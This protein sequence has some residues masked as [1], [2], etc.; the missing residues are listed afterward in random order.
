M[1]RSF[2]PHVNTQMDSNEEHADSI[3]PDLQRILCW[4]A[5]F[6]VI[7]TIIIQ[8]MIREGWRRDE[9][10]H[11][12]KNTLF[13]RSLMALYFGFALESISEL[14][15]IYGI[16]CRCILLESIHAVTWLTARCITYFFMVQRAKMSQGLA[17]VLAPKWFKYHLP[18]SIVVLWLVFA[19]WIITNRIENPS[20]YNH[21]ECVDIDDIAY[22][23][24]VY[25]VHTTENVVKVG[26]GAAIETIIFGVL[27]YL[28]VKPFL[29]IYR[30]NDVD[31]HVH[32]L[33]RHGTSHTDDL[34]TA[35]KWNVSMSAISFVSS[36]VYCVGFALFGGYF[37]YLGPVNRVL[38]IW[39]AMFM[40]GRNRNWLYINVVD[41]IGKLFHKCCC[42][43]GNNEN[44]PAA[45]RLRRISTL[46]NLS[47]KDVKL[48]IKT[49]SSSMNETI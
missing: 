26:I 34:R 9:N 36:T 4:S 40:L 44:A 30:S 7:L 12:F 6:L 18:I 35:L 28:F 22:C 42:R 15:S 19:I 1:S 48:I 2:A 16:A 13:F 21:V 3:C 23:H 29:Y 10:V 24:T 11:F 49:S 37:E 14:A 43:E 47:F 39:S 31:V 25:D 8:L 5:L 46:A 32:G 27:L 38:N 20:Q 45:V 41:K 17:P 33:H